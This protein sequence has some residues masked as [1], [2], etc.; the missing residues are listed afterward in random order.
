MQIPFN[1]YTQGKQPHTTSPAT[2]PYSSSTQ[3]SDAYC[4]GYATLPPCRVLCVETRC[5]LPALFHTR[6]THIAVP[7]I[8][9]SRILKLAKL[10]SPQLLGDGSKQVFFVDAMQL[11][12]GETY[13]CSEWGCAHASCGWQTA[14]VE[15]VLWEEKHTA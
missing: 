13:S 1:Y 14:S 8:C 11:V 3:A 2:L 10:D 7:S 15:A 6:Q 5:A 9:K 12:V 4:G